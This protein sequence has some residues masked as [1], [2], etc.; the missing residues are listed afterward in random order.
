MDSVVSNIERLVG[1]LYAP[2]G[3]NGVQKQTIEE[4]NRLLTAAQSSNEAWSFVWP[5]LAKEKDVNVQYFGASTLYTKIS[6]HFFELDA[7][8]QLEVRQRIVESIVTCLNSPHYNFVTTKLISCLSAYV[9]QTVDSSWPTALSDVVSLV[10]PEKMPHLPPSKVIF[11]LLQI[12][13]TIPE[14]FNSLYID[15]TKKIKVRA[16]LQSHAQSV[17]FIVHKVL[18]DDNISDNITQIGAKCFSNWTQ[19]LGTLVLS[20]HHANIMAIILNA[21]CSENT[22]HEAVEA[23]VDVYT[24]PH[25]EKYPKHV[26]QLIEQMSIGLEGVILK[27]S[28]EG[29]LDFCKDLYMLFIQI[30]EAHTRLLLDSLID[31]PAYTAVILKLLQIIMRCSSTPGHYGHDEYISDQPFN[32][33]ITF[34]DDIMGSDEGRIQTYLTLFKD[35]YDSL[36][37]CFLLKVQYP[38]EAIYLHEWD[39]EEREKFRCYRQ[40]IGDTFMYCFNILRSSML[41]VLFEHFNKAVGAV[42]AACKAADRSALEEAARYLEAVLYAFSSIAE[43]IDVNESAVLPQL[44]ASLH[45]IP[46]ESIAMARL[47]ETIMALF[48]AFSEWICCNLNYLQYVISVIATSLK[49][50]S[51][52]VV[53]AATMAL[54][55]ITPECQLNLQPY[56]A[57]LIELCEEHLRSPALQYK[58][59]ARLMYTLGTV[60]S[61][62]PMDVITAT[63]DRVLMPLLAE[64]EGYLRQAE[65]GGGSGGGGGE[66]VRAHLTGI[67]LILA[68]LFSKLDINLKGTDLEEGDQLVSKAAV[69]MSAKNCLKPQPLYII[70]ERVLPLFGAI[71]SRYSDSEEITENLCECIK[72]SV[73]TLLD[74]V[75]PLVGSILQLLLHLYRAS[76]SVHVLKISRQLFTLFHSSPEHLPHLQEYYVA[77]VG[78][79]VQTLLLQAADGG[80]SFHEHTY[81]LQVFYEEATAVLKKAT[82]VMATPKLDAGPLYGFAISGILLPEKSTIHQCSLFISEFLSHGRNNELFHK[83]I[84]ERFDLL[85][86]QIFAVI[87]GTYGSPSFAVDYMVDIIMAL[88]SKYSDSFARA[89]NAVVEAEAFPSACVS[90]EHKVAF[91]KTILSLRNNKRKMKDIV[92]EFSSRC[93]GLFGVDNKH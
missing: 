56:A 31:A 1:D 90:R 81:L 83:A 66:E 11:A 55:V 24:S 22:S 93:R 57:D 36:I 35:I 46:F 37:N 62:M 91:V 49:S 88:N 14:D 23:I 29:N 19:G 65:E 43:N 21:V 32:F 84:A 4:A 92:K 44:F 50:S 15:K 48:S 26:L 52:L 76:R 72:K 25:M 8:S 70:F 30:G 38:P 69:Q 39:A 7:S 80:D 77:V 10:T 64:A 51:T 75:Q 54:K 87:G 12:L 79:T 85:V 71:A 18:S 34:Q 41:K 5:L 47:L 59:K 9:I 40:D 58:D 60:L 20:E 68:N 28:A 42:F 33:W 73:I 74:D 86:T 89:L 61:V 27:A 2:S 78:V 82:P 45:S 16:E 13:T 17:L 53:V 6:K 3:C 67:L 63:I